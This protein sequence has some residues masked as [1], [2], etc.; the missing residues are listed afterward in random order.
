MLHLYCQV[1]NIMEDKIVSAQEVDVVFF[2]VVFVL[3]TGAAIV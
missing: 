2:V 3:A 1:N